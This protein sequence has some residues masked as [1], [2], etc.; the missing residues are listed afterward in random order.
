MSDCVNITNVGIEESAIG[1]NLKLY[2]NPT[3]G[4]LFIDIE[5]LVIENI[6]VFNILGETV[7]INIT[8]G[9]QIVLRN[10]S[11]GI[12]FISIETDKGTVIKKIV[13]S[14]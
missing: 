9:N 12:Y 6:T 5:N 14:L 4:M 13:K 1:N 11:R 3:S 2:P 8:N 7:D 10:S